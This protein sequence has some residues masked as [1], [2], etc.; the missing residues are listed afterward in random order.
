MEAAGEND[1]ARRTPPAEILTGGGG[2]G[3]A[4]GWQEWGSRAGYEETLPWTTGRGT[5]TNAKGT[6]MEQEWCWAVFLLPFHSPALPLSHGWVPVI[7]EWHKWEVTSALL[8]K[9]R[10]A[11]KTDRRQVFGGGGKEGP[12]PRFQKGGI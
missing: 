11:M 5:K 10:D 1:L 4:M 8:L 3:E 12:W 6:K 2:G 9:P 7:T